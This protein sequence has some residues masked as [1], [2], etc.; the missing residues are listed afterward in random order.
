[1]GDILYYVTGSSLDKEFGIAAVDR[2][3]RHSAVTMPFIKSRADAE[4]L[5]EKLNE[6]QEPISGFC[7]AFSEG[8][9]MQIV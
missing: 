5:A 1:M 4:R 7:E 3:A 8:I 6:L 2:A 9:L